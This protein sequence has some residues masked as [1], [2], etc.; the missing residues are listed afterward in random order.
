MQTVEKDVGVLAREDERRSDTHGQVAR[1]SALNAQT[2]QLVDE[3]IAHTRRDYVE[4]A[5]GAE[6][7]RVHHQA[8][9]RLAVLLQFAEHILAYNK[10]TNKHLKIS[11]PWTVLNDDDDDERIAYQCLG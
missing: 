3:L 4:G 1:R 5:E 2:A 7:A 9:I 8:R 10:Q 6:A 11:L